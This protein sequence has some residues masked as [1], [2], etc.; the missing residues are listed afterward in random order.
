M[1]L[2]GFYGFDQC[3]TGA[4]SDGTS[5]VD[6]VGPDSW[7]YPATSLTATTTI[8]YKSGSTGWTVGVPSDNAQLMGKAPKRRPLTIQT[9]SS[10]AALLNQVSIG[11][12]PGT[13]TGTIPKLILGMRARITVSDG[14]T[15]ATSSLNI[16]NVAA[17]SSGGGIQRYI[18]ALSYKPSTAMLSVGSATLSMPLG[19]E[20]RIEVVFNGNSVNVFIDG[21]ALGDAVYVANNPVFINLGIPGAVTGAND[22]AR[23]SVCDIYALDQSGSAPYNARLGDC[24]VI[25]G[26][27]DTFKTN[28]FEV[29]PNTVTAE[30]A[31]ASVGDSETLVTASGGSA[32]SA[33]MSSAPAGLDSQILAIQNLM[34]VSKDS[35]YTGTMSYH[36]TYNDGTNSGSNATVTVSPPTVGELGIVSAPLTALDAKPIDAT[37]LL[38]YTFN[39]AA[40]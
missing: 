9:G 34:T 37:L 26:S 28:T 22:W 24:K 19:Q 38:Y 21:A 10:A 40:T 32:L 2:L 8:S 20:F 30:E 39:I 18:T 25:T 29:S 17:A 14:A 23:I 15:L 33:G 35:T 3:K 31:L 12:L 4:G 27:Y 1:A 13:Y 7:S 16:M 36:E 11:S 5:P 6:G